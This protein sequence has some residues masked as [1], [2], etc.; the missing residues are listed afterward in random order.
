MRNADRS[1]QSLCPG[2]WRRTA[3]RTPGASASPAPRRAE[4]LRSL[5]LRV[6]QRRVGAKPEQGRGDVGLALV[7]GHVQRGLAALSMCVERAEQLAD[8]RVT[9]AGR[10]VQRGL[11]ATVRVGRVGPVLD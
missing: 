11:T 4:L 7:G 2:P 3:R 5:A 10:D 6:A 9:V 1:Y 8:A